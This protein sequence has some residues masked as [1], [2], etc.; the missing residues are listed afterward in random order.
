MESHSVA[1]HGVVSAH[2]NLCLPGF[3]RFSCLSLLSSWDYSRD[4]V[5]PCWPGWSP[6]PDLVIH[7]PWPPKMLE[8]QVSLPSP[9]LKYSGAIMSHCSLDFPGSSDPPTSA[10]QV[11]GAT[12]GT[13]NSVSSGKKE[14]CVFTFQK[15]KVSLCRQAGVQWCNLGSPQPLPPGFKQFSCLSLQHSW[16]YRHLPTS[17][18]NFCIFSKDGVSPCWP[19]WSPSL[20]LV[21]CRPRPPKGMSHCA[22]PSTFFFFF[23]TE[24][25]S[26]ARLECSGT[27]LAHCNLCLLDSSDSP[28]SAS[29]VAGA[30]GVHHHT[31]S[32]LQPSS[33]SPASGPI[34]TNYIIVFPCTSLTL[35]PRLE[36][37]DTISAHCNLCPPGFKRFSCLSLPSVSHRT[38]PR[39]Q[40]FK[41]VMIIFVMCSTFLTGFHHVGQA[42]LELLTSGNPPALASKV[43]GLQ[44]WCLV[45]SPR[46]ECNGAIL[47]HCN[48]CLW[49]SSD[50]PALASQIVGITRA[51]HYTWLIFVFLVEMG[52][53]HVGQAGLKL[54]TSGDP[55]ASASQSP[56]ITG[57]SHCARPGLLTLSKTPSQKE[58]EKEKKESTG[59]VETGFH[60]V[61]HAGLK[62]LTSNDLPASVFQS[63]GITGMSHRAQP[64]FFFL[65]GP[66]A[67]V[68]GSIEGQR[69]NMLSHV[70]M[71]MN[72]SSLWGY[73]G[74]YLGSWMESPWKRAWRKR[75]MQLRQENHLNPGGGG[76]D[77]LRLCHCTLAW[78]ARMKLHLKKTK[79]NKKKTRVI[80]RSRTLRSPY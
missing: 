24:S 14:C 53:H 34:C 31:Q 21:I 9:R 22:R 47:A 1:R 18:A 4:G 71:M 16:D 29:R 41:A 50:S 69:M 44:G 5:S 10:S 15:M 72:H 38:R 33:A 6:S 60:H 36:C 17:L 8:L 19:G 52:Y 35:S 20:D 54:L 25:H 68:G 40:T 42:G 67:E 78:A 45:L 30:T 73:C 57:V 66:D 2:C 51:R 80:I 63:A 28:A 77:E 3:K 70:Y 46:L 7:L 12:D 26:V 32:T 65:K 62:L 23:E 49:G 56:G 58:K 55:L 76:Y 64:T 79:Q 43:L 37:S 39:I 74:E 11:A 48:L 27:I 75:N 13:L 59:R 61:G